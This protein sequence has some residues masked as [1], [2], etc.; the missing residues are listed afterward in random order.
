[1]PGSSGSPCSICI[2]TARLASLWLNTL[3]GGSSMRTA[4]LTDDQIVGVIVG[5]LHRMYP[6]AAA[7]QQ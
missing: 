6:I 7:G 5:A 3:F 2:C 4:G 1:M